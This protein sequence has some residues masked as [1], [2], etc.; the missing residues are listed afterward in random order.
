MKADGLDMIFVEISMADKDGIPVANA[1]NR[2]EVT[3]SGAG[4]LVGLDN[5]DS[6][7]FD[8]YKGTSRSLFS[9]KLLA[10]VAA[11]QEPGQIRFSVSSP[12]LGTEELVFEA[13]PCEKIPGVS[14]FTEN[15]NSSRSTR[16]R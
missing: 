3:V 12:G 9:G 14:A 6:T 8:Q 2:V 11:K 4:R 15:K 5:G 13:V 16:Y 7:D 1:N 10:M